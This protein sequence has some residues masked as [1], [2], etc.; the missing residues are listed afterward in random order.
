MTKPATD[1]TKQRILGFC[2]FRRDGYDQ[3]RA[4]MS[5]PERLFDGFDQWL[6]AARTIERE[7]TAK[8]EKVVRIRFD[9][10]AFLLWCA[11]RGRLPDEQSRAGWA[12]DEV[13]KKYGVRA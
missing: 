1:E 2:W 3:A 4:I 12:A 8:G 6:A 7:V 10:P 5:D 13:R 11:A 9:L